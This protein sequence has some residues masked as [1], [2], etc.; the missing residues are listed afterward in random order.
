MSQI[1]GRNKCRIHLHN[2]LQMLLIRGRDLDEIELLGRAANKD[3][4]RH[5]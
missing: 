3:T 4:S 5:V 1:L 2:L